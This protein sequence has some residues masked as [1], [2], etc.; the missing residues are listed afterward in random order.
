[1]FLDVYIILMVTSYSVKCVSRLMVY[2]SCWMH[3]GV[4]RT[5]LSVNH[6][7]GLQMIMKNIGQTDNWSVSIKSSLATV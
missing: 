1:L 3:S 7:L 6:L 4:V 2:I 5:L